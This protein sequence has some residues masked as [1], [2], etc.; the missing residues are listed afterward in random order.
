ML[1]AFLIFHIH[2]PREMD[3][4]SIRDIY[5]LLFNDRMSLVYAGSFKDNITTKAIKLSEH[6]LDKSEEVT[7]LKKKSS[8]LM[9][10]C[11]QNVVRH[12]EPDKSSDY[13]PAEQGFFMTRSK[14][15][16]YY[17][18]SSNIIEK[19]LVP[20]LKKTLK[21]LNEKSPEE[22][23]ELYMTGLREKGLSEKGGAG[24]GLIEMARK[25][26]H[27]L[28]FDFKKMSDKLYAYYLLIHIKSS[29]SEEESEM[30]M[31]QDVE[32]VHQIMID[33]DIMLIY[34]GDFSLEAVAPIINMLDTNLQAHEIEH[35]ENKKVFVTLVEMIQNISKHGLDYK[36]VKYGLLAIGRKN[37]KFQLGAGNFIK[38]GSK[39][40]IIKHIEMINNASYDELRVMLREA[41][42][43]TTIEDIDGQIGLL[44]VAKTS[45]KKLHYEFN[46]DVGDNL[47]YSFMVKF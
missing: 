8:F 29:K 31:I 26:G 40:K 32:K 41:L 12:N 37:G 14:G 11:F 21:S 46:D 9:A 16:M 44:D 7:N 36:G 38:K 19:E 28:T 15:H 17:I 39:K 25:S 47:F 23:K 3:I 13:H 10:E 20:E 2:S 27:P 34:K 42:L 5:S 30:M 35:Y 6:N 43:K 18:A 33:N 22:L 24:L 45:K 1:E 4:H